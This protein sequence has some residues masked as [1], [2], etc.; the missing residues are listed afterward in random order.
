M[1]G[2]KQIQKTKTTQVTTR[3]A[4]TQAQSLAIVQTLLH[5]GLSNLAYY[6]EL[7]PE[8]VFDIQ[9]YQ[10]DRIP[11]FEDYAEGRLGASAKDGKKPRTQV[12]NVAVMRRERSK[13][14]DKFLKHLVSL[15]FADSG[16]D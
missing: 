1:G 12:V 9:P 11:S 3:T 16:S 8:R 4:I 6:R 5:G 2:T 10:A 7:F 14:L 13:R 15:K